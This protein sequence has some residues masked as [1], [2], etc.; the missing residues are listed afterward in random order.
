MNTKLIFGL[1][2]IS[3]FLICGCRKEKTV[4]FSGRFLFTKK[5]PTPVANRKIEL[6]Q[7]G[8][9]AAIGIASG[10]SSAEANGATDANGSYHIGFK[11]GKSFFIIFSGSN[12]NDLEMHSTDSLFPSFSRNNIPSD[13]YEESSPQYIGKIIDTAIIKVRIATTTTLAPSDT[14]ALNAMTLS[15]NIYREYTGMN[16]AAGSDFVIDTIYNM[17]FTDFDHVNRTFWNNLEVGRLKTS[18]G[19]KYLRSEMVFPYELSSNDEGSK[20]LSFY[21]TQ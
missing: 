14:V 6:Y 21:I 15:G 17:L 18:W 12:G 11:P 10:S 16:A 20:E 2:L 1:I 3:S 7:R 4:V 9:G 13:G 8:S 19:S 5:Y